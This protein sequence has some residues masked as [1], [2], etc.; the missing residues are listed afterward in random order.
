MSLDFTWLSDPLYQTWM[1]RGLGTTV[2]M[3]ACAIVLMFAIGI[4]GAAIIYFRVPVPET[5]TTIVVE[6]LRNTPPLVQ[7]FVLYSR[8][9]N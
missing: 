8:C 1:L 9:R 2:A 7:L 5:L 6:M 4:V 3:C